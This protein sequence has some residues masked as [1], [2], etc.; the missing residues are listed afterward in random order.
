MP[1]GPEVKII[2]NNIKKKII[3]KTNKVKLTNIINDRFSKTPPKNFNKLIKQLPLDIIDINTKGKFTY[4]T[5]ENDWYIWITMGLT[6]KLELTSS[7]Y[8]RIEF[9]TN[10]DSF[11]FDDMIGYG[12]IKFIDNIEETSKKLS[13]ELGPDLLQEVISQEEFNTQVSL[14]T[15]KN[16]ELH[17]ILVDQKVLSGIGNYLRSDILYYAKLSPYRTIKSLSSSELVTLHEAIIHLLK[18]NY[19]KQMKDGLQHGPKF[20][21]YKKE[22][23]KDGNK[24]KVD[25]I[26][27]RKLYWIEKVQK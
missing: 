13:K 27:K 4:I 16:K 5:L 2:V 8:T 20:L 3:N 19:N 7:K 22:I 9:K 11:Y 15:R 12:S 17:D 21:I 18:L 14:K 26:K 10:K 24:V 23:D 1:E 6:G 25:V